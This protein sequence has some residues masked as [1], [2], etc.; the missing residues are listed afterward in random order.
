MAPAE[1]PRRLAVQLPLDKSLE[2]VVLATKM[3]SP[4]CTQ[5]AAKA[6]AGRKSSRPVLACPASPASYISRLPSESYARRVSSSLG[7]RQRSRTNWPQKE[8]GDNPGLVWKTLPRPLTDA[9][10]S[11]MV[12][13]S[14]PSMHAAEG[15]RPSVRGRC[16]YWFD[17]HRDHTTFHIASSQVSVLSAN[18]ISN[19]LICCNV[20]YLANQ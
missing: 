18:L 1:P 9:S 4:S 7:K 5:A 2:E 16:L 12:Q 3:V 13:T 14:S 10:T 8:C 19:T 20:Q 15:P 6:A 17:S 11:H